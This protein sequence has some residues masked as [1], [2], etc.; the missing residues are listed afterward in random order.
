MSGRGGRIRR[1][2][3]DECEGLGREVGLSSTPPAG[4]IM[5][6]ID[7]HPASCTQTLVMPVPLGAAGSLQGWDQYTYRTAGEGGVCVWV[8]EGASSP[9]FALWDASFLMALALPRTST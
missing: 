5:Q 2:E 4:Y 3:R 9:W 1:L 8:C 7:C 6:L